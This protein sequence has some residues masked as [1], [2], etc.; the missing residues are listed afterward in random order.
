MFIPNAILVLRGV[1]GITFLLVKEVLEMVDGVWWEI[2]MR[3][4]G[5]R[6]GVELIVVLWRQLRWNVLNLVISLR[7]LSWLI[8]LF[9][10]GNSLGFNRVEE[11]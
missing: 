4:V 3:F 9:L 11:R 7:S 10:V 2:L 6:R 5:V 1:F 8:F